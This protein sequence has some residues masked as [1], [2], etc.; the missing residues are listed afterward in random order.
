MI[1]HENRPFELYLVDLSCLFENRHQDVTHRGLIM[2]FIPDDAAMIKTPIFI[3][4][5]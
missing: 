5:P 1:C 3:F 2:Y 4:K